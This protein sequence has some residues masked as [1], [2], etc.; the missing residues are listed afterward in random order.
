MRTSVY[1]CY[2]AHVLICL[3][4]FFHSTNYEPQ[5]HIH[6][7][8]W[9]LKLYVH[10]Y[11][12]RVIVSAVLIQSEEMHIQCTTVVYMY[13]YMIDMYVCGGGGFVIHVHYAYK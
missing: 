11:S 12:H 3:C 8:P 7:P 5:D 13:M 1:P 6:I 4:Y 10:V 9:L 2:G